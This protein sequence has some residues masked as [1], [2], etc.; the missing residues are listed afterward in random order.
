MKFAPFSV[1][2]APFNA[3]FAPFN[4]H[5]AVLFPFYVFL[6]VLCL[7]LPLFLLLYRMAPYGTIWFLFLR[8]L[9]AA[10]SGPADAP[11]DGLSWAKCAF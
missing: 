8:T 1:H 11:Q 7:L 5:F 3:H 2:F 10:P 9:S 4:P 6:L